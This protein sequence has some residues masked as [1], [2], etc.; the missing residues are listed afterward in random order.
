MKETHPKLLKDLNKLISP[1]TR[2]DPE[3]PLRWTSK[4]TVAL[5]DEL[6]KIRTP[7]PLLPKPFYYCVFHENHA[8]EIVILISQPGA[9]GTKQEFK[10]RGAV[11]QRVLKGR[12]L[13]LCAL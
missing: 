10:R 3:N 9:A 4:S 5:A 1:V 11:S 13:H 12:A 2:G 8:P 6:Q 7:D